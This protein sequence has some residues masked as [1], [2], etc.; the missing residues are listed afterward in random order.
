M[1]PD[2]NAPDLQKRGE[3]LGEGTFEIRRRGV[4][5]I[6]EHRGDRIHRTVS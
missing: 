4:T 1:A 3:D 6:L 2:R 5:P